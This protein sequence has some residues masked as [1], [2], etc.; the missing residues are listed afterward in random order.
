MRK[1]DFLQILLDFNKNGDSET[2]ITTDQLKAVLLDIMVGGTDTSSTM[3]EWAMA[4]I[5]LHQ[6]VMKK[7][8]QELDEVVGINNTVEDSHLHKLKYLDAVLKETLRLHPALPLLLP[9]VSSQ[10]TTLGGYT[11]PKGTAVFVNVYAIHRDPLFWD[12]PLEFIPERFLISESS[13]FDY[14]GNNFQYLPLG[15][16]RRVCAGIPLAERM[17]MYVLASFLHSFEWKLPQG[18]ELELSDKFGIVVKKMKP[19]I[20]VPKPRLSNVDLY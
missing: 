4:E 17:V 10:S 9:H 7:V 11:I 15:S 3:L 19:L 16:G 8:Y 14:S 12:N 13:K 5:M 6:E 18:T 2:S 20:L 1:K